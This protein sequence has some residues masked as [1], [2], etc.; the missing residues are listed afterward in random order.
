V[1]T[2][3]LR[4]EPFIQILCYPSG[5]FEE[6][7][8]RIQ[9]LDELGIENIVFEGIT[10]IGSLRLLGKGCVS[11]VVKAEKNGET[12]ALKIRRTDANRPNMRN[13]A[14]L[15]KF[16]N[17]IEVGP[18]VHQISDNFLL[19][20]LVEGES[21]IKWIKNLSGVGTTA[22][23]RD[24]A[25]KVLSQC[26][27]LDKAGIDHGELSNLEKHV[28]VGKQVTIIDFETASLQRRVSNLTSSIQNIF[29]GGAQARK[30]RR[31]LRYKE[32]QP[33]ID[34]VRTYKKNRSE[35]NFQ[36]ILTELKLD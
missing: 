26:Y 7:S 18:K 35:T 13:E 12:Y 33:I 22:K 16:A 11:L 27:I 23:M 30:V 31:I 14:K 4:T 9:E 15:T 10:K 5:D 6:A 17:Q 1:K 28:Y 25:K 32:I 36:K 34:V 24:V 20:D 8:R 19:L 21:I 29:I 2:S 3:Q